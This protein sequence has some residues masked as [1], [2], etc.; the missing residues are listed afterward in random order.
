M[1]R[2]FCVENMS[3]QPDGKKLLI[4]QSKT[5][6]VNGGSVRNAVCVS[7]QCDPTIFVICMS[8]F[9]QARNQFVQSRRDSENGPCRYP[10]PRY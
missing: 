6:L 9:Y 5:S 7:S 4:A 2:P 8:A 10:S 3:P 1:S